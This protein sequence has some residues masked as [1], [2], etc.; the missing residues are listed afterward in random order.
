[1]NEILFVSGRQAFWY[2]PGEDFGLPVRF[3][4]IEGALST[5]QRHEHRRVIAARES[6]NLGKTPAARA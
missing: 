6:T 1:M 2:D 4:A 3:E 5:P